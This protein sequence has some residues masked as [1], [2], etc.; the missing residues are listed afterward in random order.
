MPA[1]SDGLPFAT[2]RFASRADTADALVTRALSHVSARA[3]PR[4]LDL[5]C[6]TG[7]V[8]IQAARSRPDLVTVALDI[9]PANIAAARASADLA[10]VGDRVATVCADY[11]RWAG[12]S[13][14]VIVSDSVL[15]LIEGN[16][17]AL[18]SQLA[19][20]LAQGGVLIATVPVESVG[21][22]IRIMQ[23]RIWRAAPPAADRLILALARR[24]YPQFSTEALADRLPYLRLL[25]V[26][27]FGPELLA[28][29][30]RYGLNVIAQEPW[31]S[32]SLAKLDHDLIVWRRQ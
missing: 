11:L 24:L 18:A 29:F 8:A 9:A 1:S 4:L 14:D 12:G 7:Q 31:E 2:I 13:F 23:R 26:R 19:H 16:D 3:S 15:N 6:G 10:G 30:A 20:D 22:T 17:Q 28:H 5:G 27:L 25:P 21:N 32:P